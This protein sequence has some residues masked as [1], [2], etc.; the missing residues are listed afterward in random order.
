MKVLMSGY[1]GFAGT[2]LM[3]YTKEK[4][5]VTGLTRRRESYEQ[6]ATAI[7]WEELTN[8]PMPE[9]DAVVHL[10]GKAHDMKNT[11]APAAYFEANTYLTQQLFDRF[12]QS[13]A[14]YFIYCSSVKAAA[15]EVTGML[16][17]EAAPNPKTIYGKSKQ[18]AEAYLQQQLL[19]AG[20]YLYILR[21]C[22]I[23]GPG[24]KGNLNLLYGFVQR[25]IPYPLSAFENRR[26]FL[27]VENLSFVVTQLL[28]SGGSIPSG[29]YNLADDESLSTNDLIQIMEEVTGKHVR[30]W[31]ISPGFIRRMARIGD[32]IRFPLNTDR[33]QKLTSSY[34]VSNKKIKQMLGL[35][36][37]PIDARSGL[38][39]TIRSFQ[40]E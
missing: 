2:N 26:S 5:H 33:L 6:P 3:A 17:E 12:L 23:H 27:S 37:L 1:R 16:T 7:T 32:V 14:K 4:W 10:A 34:E 39:A 28:E 25:G 24:N 11:S 36:R 20:K 21:P 18:M 22:M 13:D 15:D 40:S 30:K 35:D 38:T 8:G 9:V 31:H 29:V 19:P